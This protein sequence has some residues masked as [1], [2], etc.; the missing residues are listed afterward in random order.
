[1]VCG[2]EVSGPGLFPDLG[3]E[4]V[5]GLEAQDGQVEPVVGVVPPEL[6]EVFHRVVGRPLGISWP[7]HS[8]SRWS[9]FDIQASRVDR[10]MEGSSPASRSSRRGWAG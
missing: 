9:F 3:E 2:D 5:L 8:D 10:Q 6:P 4:R 1:M 7:T